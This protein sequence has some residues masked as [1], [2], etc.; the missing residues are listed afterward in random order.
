M[1]S[2]RFDWNDY[3]KIA[4][5]LL[6]HITNEAAYRVAASRAYYAV[7]WKAR[8]LI[9]A[10]GVV[11]PSKNPH[12]FVWESFGNTWDS[13]GSSIAKLGSDIKWLRV[14]ADYKSLPCMVKQDAEK[15]VISAEDLIKA[16]Q[17]IS[18]EN[19]SAVVSHAISLLA[20]PEYSAS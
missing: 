4:N 1:S 8:L 12:K 13:H 7:Y 18:T 6:D 17:E 14:W 2:A 11:I 20:L 19:Q 3:L 15:A 5:N 16:L 10:N 9:E